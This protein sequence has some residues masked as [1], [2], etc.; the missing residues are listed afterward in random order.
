M[1]EEQA[2]KHHPEPRKQR[3]IVHRGETG[4]YESQPYEPVKVKSERGQIPA[5]KYECRAEVKVQVPVAEQGVGK[6]YWKADAVQN[7]EDYEAL[8]DEKPRDK[9]Y[10]QPEGEYLQATKQILLYGFPRPDMRIAE[11][12]WYPDQEEEDSYYQPWKV[13][14][15]ELAFKAVNPEQP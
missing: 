1:A 9:R 5:Q 2:Q 13:K 6:D 14:P 3:D 7:T 10:Q 15:E 4:G 11:R 12:E 8:P